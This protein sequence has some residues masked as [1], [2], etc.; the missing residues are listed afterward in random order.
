MT[1]HDRHP[2]LTPQDEAF[3]AANPWIARLYHDRATSVPFSPGSRH[4]RPTPPAT[5]LNERLFSR[6]LLDSGAV[7][8]T[9]GWHAPLDFASVEAAVAKQEQEQEAAAAESNGVEGEAGGV[10]TAEEKKGDMYL[11][12]EATMAFDLGEGLRGFQGVTHGG[13][14]AVLIDEC[15]GN[16]LALNQAV[17]VKA[18]QGGFGKERG[19]RLCK[20]LAGLGGTTA[21]TV[22][23]DVR[24]LKPIAVP[25]AVVVRTWLGSITGRKIVV[26]SVIEGEGGVRY[27]T[28][29]STWIVVK[30]PKSKI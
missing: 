13:M 30:L 28:C 7:A 29:D 1:Y 25:A 11:I 12:P 15:V 18:E 14:F 19:Q 6:T 4:E 24:F 23:M 21:Y 26:K 8:P 2:A 17:S 27:G 20:R 3:L 9:L 16:Y 5:A 10:S 22:G